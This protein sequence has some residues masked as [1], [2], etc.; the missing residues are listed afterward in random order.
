[1]E[2][3]RNII[4]DIGNVILHF[5]LEEVLSHFTKDEYEKKF[6][7][8]NV[9]HS[10]EWLG[11]S[12]ID[13]GFLSLEQA[14]SI[15]EDRTNHENDELIFRFWHHYNDYCFLDDR[16]ISLLS[17]LKENGYGIYLLSNIN[18]HTFSA[19]QDNRLFK[20]VDGYVFSYLEHQVKPY[21][22]IYFTLLNRFKLR[23]E[24]CL[25]IDDNI[26]NV[27]TAKN[28][29]ILSWVVIPDSY[30]SL[31]EVLEKNNLIKKDS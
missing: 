4:F 10:P 27:I 16:V 24:E 28:L 30:D 15:V 12:L 25:F 7:L 13:T 5:D 9:I 3:I 29:G 20:L 31:V 14:I 17:S 18:A 11:Y 6:L 22:S 2:N 23:P 1:M 26:K 8:E 19:I 21:E